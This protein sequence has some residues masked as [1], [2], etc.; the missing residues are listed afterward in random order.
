MHS[1]LPSVLCFPSVLQDSHTKEES[2]SDDLILPRVR[3]I[4]NPDQIRFTNL[5]LATLGLLHY[6]RKRSPKRFVKLNKENLDL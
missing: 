3:D 2:C 6:T 1:N 4:D 5:P